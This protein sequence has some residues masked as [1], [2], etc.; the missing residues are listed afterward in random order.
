MNMRRIP[1]IL[2]FGALV[3]FLILSGTGCTKKARAEKHMRAADAM[4]AAG[5]YDRAEAEYV[6]TIRTDHELP[7]PYA[8]LGILY[9][10]EGRL[11]HAY[12]FLGRASQMDS[13]NLDLKI[14]LAQLYLA[15]GPG[16]APAS[17]RL[18]WQVMT[19]RPDDPEAPM[20]FAEA[21]LRLDEMTD[22]EKKLKDQEKTAK[23]TPSYEVALGSLAFRNRDFKTALACFEN[24]QKADP[25]FGPAYNALATV[26]NSMGDKQKTEE[27]FQKS[28]A[29]APVRSQ[30]RLRY[31]Q[32]KLENHDVEAAKHLLNDIIQQAPDYLPALLLMADINAGELKYDQAATL[33]DKVLKRDPSNFDALFLAGRLSMLQDDPQAAIT[34]FERM[35]RMWTNNSGVFYHLG[36]AQIAANDPVNA[37]AS[38][39]QAIALRP[40]FGEALMAQ[41]QL[42]LN[43]GETAQAITTLK[44]MVRSNPQSMSG[45]LMLGD[46]YRQQGDYQEAM[47]IF[48]NVENSYPLNS[49]PSYKVGSM[50]LAAGRKDE[51]RQEFIKS[52]QIDPGYLPSVEHLSDLECEKGNFTYALSLVEAVSKLNTNSPQPSELFA[53]IHMAEHDYYRAKGD[54]NKMDECARL[55]EVTLEKAIQVHTNFVPGILLLARV[56]HELGQTKDAVE[57]LKNLIQAY[58]KDQD[59]LLTLAT[60]Q[61]ETKDV[62][63]A[64]AT[65]EK[66]LAINPAHPVALNNLSYIFINQ[67][68]LDKALDVAKRAHDALPNNAAVNDTLG[69]VLFKLAKYEQAE[70]ILKTAGQR[71]PNEGEVQLHLGLAHYMAGNGSEALDHLEFALKDTNQ[72]AGKDMAAAC[73]PILKLNPATATPDDVAMLEK[74]LAQHADD[75]I[76]LGL[77]SAIQK[78]DGK[79][80][81]AVAGYQ[82]VLKIN[83]KNLTAL[84]E[85]ISYYQTIPDRQKDAYDLAMSAYKLAAD[86]NTIAAAMGR[87]SY[88]QKDYPYAMNVL[89]SLYDRESDKDPNLAFDLAKALYA[90]G[91]VA[92]AREK[93]R[94]ALAAGPAFTN[95]AAANDF[96]QMTDLGAAGANPTVTEAQADELLKSRPDYVPALMVKGILSAKN[97]KSQPA[98]QYFEQVLLT[99]PDF[100]AAKRE[101]AILYA[102]EPG[103]DKKAYDY[104]AK[105]HQVLP[106][107]NELTQALGI[108][109][110]RQEDYERSTKIFKQLADADDAN[111]IARYYLGMSFYKTKDN[112]SAKRYLSSSMERGLP[113]ALSAEAKKTLSQIK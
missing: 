32:F 57:L 111:A 100:V 88:G 10:D 23:Y 45:Q 13:N 104:A 91:M 112:M 14:K 49:E 84:K 31:V 97:G 99:Y 94:A 67:G 3:V 29:N 64:R 2:G 42:K 43:R 79:I 39:D 33:T 5:E 27:N 72:F 106:D 37:S 53:K 16:S 38:L 48:K 65:Y 22:A 105:A 19:N 103:D 47:N 76:A 102:K 93:A 89:Q 66:L 73:I 92:P 75:Q 44:E 96:L 69:W 80:D 101:L 60:Y 63:G 46:A 18:A 56:R 83:P 21:S 61:E 36:L 6:N 26:Y 90:M 11:G 12:Y 85:L 55:A 95:A 81:K 68:Y 54:T 70:T 24:A 40:G 20:I 35:A 71:M 113:D 59:G 28:I 98:K 110:Y 4:L 77:L 86:D 25:T 7:R 82:S 30:R 41:A 107:D 52:I 1:S 62:E 108:L 109:A 34:H 74:Q 50:L 58:P 17:R 8:K 15:A 9:F 51:A 87:L 78:R